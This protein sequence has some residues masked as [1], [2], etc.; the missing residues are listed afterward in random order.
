MNVCLLIYVRKSGPMKIAVLL[1]T[2]NGAKY[3]PEYLESMRQQTV[4]QFK[5]FIRD[6][7]STDDTLKIIQEY[8]IRNHHVEIV[9]AGENVGVIRSFSLL[10]EYALEKSSFEYFMFADQDDVWLPHKI[11]ISLL[12]MMEMESEYN[13]RPILVH[14]DL[15]VVDKHLKQL[16]SSFWRYQNLDPQYCQLNRLLVQNVITGCTMLINA[17]LAKL[18]VSFPQGVIMHDWWLGLVAAVFGEISYISEPTILYRQH[19][20]NSVGARK[21]SIFFVA[22]RM[23]APVILTKNYKQA[24][25]IV[26]YFDEELNKP[27]LA[28][29]HTVLKAFLSIDRTSYIRRYITTLSFKF[30]KQGLLRNIGLLFHLWRS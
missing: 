29:K 14:S 8:R 6:D 3:L 13:K 15:L 19:E 26:D 21:F 28:I 20:I 11:E 1:S 2:Y 4:Q 23:F 22:R 9:S 30:L 18:S 10:L 7:G 12:R 27:Q 5:L 16:S 17:P 24:Q 25:C